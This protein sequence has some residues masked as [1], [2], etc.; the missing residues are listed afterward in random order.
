M[1]DAEHD[2]PGNDARF[3][4]QP[5][6]E[7]AAKTSSGESGTSVE[8]LDAVALRDA[9]PGWRL[10]GAT[11]YWFAVRGGVE[12]TT[13]P[14]SLLRRCISASTIP[15]LADKLCLQEYLDGLNDCELEGVWQQLRLPTSSKS[16]AS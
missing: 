10:G 13:G 16:A 5:R 15:T 3:I 11:G 9:F 6:A 1:A 12:V 2:E 7:P 8:H 4:G 14:R